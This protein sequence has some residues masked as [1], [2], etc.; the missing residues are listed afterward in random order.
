MCDNETV[1]P[2]RT[3]YGNAGS[4]TNGDLKLQEICTYSSLHDLIASAFCN[5]QEQLNETQYKLQD[6]GQE[7]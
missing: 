5:M 2:G 1:F 7:I 3:N 4:T 6:C